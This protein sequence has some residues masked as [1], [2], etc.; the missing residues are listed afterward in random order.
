MFLRL[1]RLKNIRELYKTKVEKI[2]PN[3]RKIC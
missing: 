1:F 2:I 3:T